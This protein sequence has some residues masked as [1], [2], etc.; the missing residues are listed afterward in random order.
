MDD[1]DK[2]KRGPDTDRL[3]AES[4]G[5][6]IRMEY[7]VCIIRKYDGITKE[8]KPSIDLNDAFWA[9]ELLGKLIEIRL[10]TRGYARVIIYP[11]DHEFEMVTTGDEFPEMAICKAIL[12]LKAK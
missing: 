2:L 7:G 8:F 12:A 3:V 6:F 9:T 1:I 10:L 11:D 5:A 4:L